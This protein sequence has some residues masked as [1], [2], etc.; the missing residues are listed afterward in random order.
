MHIETTGYGG[1]NAGFISESI[2]FH[3]FPIH[4]HTRLWLCSADRS[5]SKRRTNERRI[6]FP[7]LKGTKRKTR[8]GCLLFLGR[9]KIEDLSTDFLR[10]NEWVT[11]GDRRNVIRIIRAC[12]IE[13]TRCAFSSSCDSFHFDYF[14]SRQRKL[15]YQHNQE[16]VSFPL[17][18]RWRQI[19]ECATLF[20][21]S[22]NAVWALEIGSP[23]NWETFNQ[24]QAIFTAAALDR[25][26]VA[27][28]LKKNCLNTFLYC[29]PWF[30][31]WRHLRIL[32]KD[33]M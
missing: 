30:Y 4:S 19:I 20:F 10:A 29:N 25:I 3:W 2:N 22:V 14:S 23:I 21:R 8:R 15:I 16:H 31:Q 28:K 13:R 9:D 33:Q 6:Y 26:L 18:V 17:C 7:R 32:C 11:R 5:A 12:D 27:N 24:L 1:Y